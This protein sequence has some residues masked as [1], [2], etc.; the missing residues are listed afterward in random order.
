MS[1]RS[2]VWTDT[3]TEH[4]LALNGG[5]SL[6]GMSSELHTAGLR[7]FYHDCACAAHCTMGDR[8]H[9]GPGARAKDGRFWHITFAS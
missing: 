2:V 3:V 9:C 4:G 5:Q 7:A 8:A 1:M 6:R